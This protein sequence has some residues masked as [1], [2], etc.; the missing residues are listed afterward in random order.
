M[1]GAWSV[2]IDILTPEARARRGVRPHSRR[3]YGY[4]AAVEIAGLCER[5]LYFRDV[6]SRAEP[7]VHRLA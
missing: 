7:E 2:R 6:A 1:S 4:W 3:V 5:K